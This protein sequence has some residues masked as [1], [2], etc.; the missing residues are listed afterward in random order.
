MTRQPKLHNIH[1]LQ[2]EL[3]MTKRGLGIGEWKTGGRCPL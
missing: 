3:G 2:G 1:Y